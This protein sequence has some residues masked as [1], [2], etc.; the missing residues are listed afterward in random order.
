MIAVVR[1][2]VRNMTTGK[3]W[4]YDERNIRRLEG[5]ESKDVDHLRLAG[6]LCQVKTA[7]LTLSVTV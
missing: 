6:T 7:L 5:L 1:F 4:W 2:L 3:S